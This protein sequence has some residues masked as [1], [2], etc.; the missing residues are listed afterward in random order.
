MPRNLPDENVCKAATKATLLHFDRSIESQNVTILHGRARPNQFKGHEHFGYLDGI[1]Q[2]AIRYCPL[3]QTKGDLTLISHLLRGLIA[4][5][6][7]QIQVN[8]GVIIAGYKGD[9]ALDRRPTWVKDGSFMAFRKLQQLVPEFNQY[10]AKNGP[11]W[12]EFVPKVDANPPLSSEE[13]AAL[14]GARMVGRWPS[15]GTVEV[16]IVTF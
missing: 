4:P 16:S 14:W 13:G 7:G 12:K 8:A 9:P 11:R 3:Y 10:L 6:P 1:S 2:P 5:L 15:V